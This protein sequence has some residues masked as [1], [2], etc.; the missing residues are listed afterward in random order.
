MYKCSANI[1]KEEDK[2]AEQFR[3]SEA[4]ESDERYASED[5][6]WNREQDVNLGSSDQRELDDVEVDITGSDIQQEADF[7][8]DQLI[9]SS[10]SQQTQ[11]YEESTQDMDV[12]ANSQLELPA[13]EPQQKQ[14]G[15]MIQSQADSEEPHSDAAHEGPI[16]GEP[17]SSETDVK[18]SNP[19]ED[20]EEKPVFRLVD[21][22]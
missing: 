17:P 14:E 15:P 20:T 2:E 7:N 13:E 19:H 18:L 3:T 21:Y 4:E 11:L 8:Q 6:E 5:E 22:D 1:P 9:E 10:E 16:P 12:Q